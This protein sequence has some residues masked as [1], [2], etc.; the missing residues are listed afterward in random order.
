[1]VSIWLGE[2]FLRFPFGA[3]RFKAYLALVIAFAVASLLLADEQP[4]REALKT[5]RK[6]KEATESLAK[7]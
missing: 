1:M 3:L 7:L 5:L 2:V 4:P 6:L